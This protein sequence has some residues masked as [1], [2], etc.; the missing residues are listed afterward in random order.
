MAKFGIAL[1]SGPRGR[2]FESRCSDQKEK[3]C[4]CSP[5]L[6]T[7]DA[8]FMG[9]DRNQIVGAVLDSNLLH[10]LYLLNF[11]LC[12]AIIKA[13]DLNLFDGFAPHPSLPLHNGAL[14]APATVR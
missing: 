14:G 1:G 9:V 11:V 2:G 13:T 3:G 7:L 8:P 6:F 4:L 12:S 10:D 5:F